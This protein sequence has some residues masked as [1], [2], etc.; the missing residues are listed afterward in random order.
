MEG[1]IKSLIEDAGITEG[2][3]ERGGPSLTP[4]PTFLLSDF[5]ITKKNRKKTKTNIFFLIIN[6]QINEGGG[7]DGGSE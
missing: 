4:S 2:E 6:D 3:G 7:G 5:F 1:I